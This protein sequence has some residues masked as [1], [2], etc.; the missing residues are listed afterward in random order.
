M[1]D[2]GRFKRA[3]GAL[4]SGLNRSR[5]ERSDHRATVSAASLEVN[6]I[7][8]TEKQGANDASVASAPPRMSQEVAQLA[9]R[10]RQ[11]LG[12]GQRHY[13][14]MVGTGPIEAAA[15]HDENVLG[16]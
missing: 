9:D 5:A 1:R 10:R 2:S 16:A 15:G 4:P 7:P 11:V 6:R 13:A 14:Q 8:P 12:A 3:D